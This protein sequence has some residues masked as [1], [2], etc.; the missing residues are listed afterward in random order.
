MFQENLEFLPSDGCIPEGLGHIA[1]G[2]FGIL[3][4]VWYI[5]RG[6]LQENFE[7]LSLDWCVLRGLGTYGSRT[8]F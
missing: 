8:F 7:M 1:Q 6:F 4:L 5:L 3:S 2:N